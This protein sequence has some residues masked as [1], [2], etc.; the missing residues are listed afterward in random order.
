MLLLLAALPG[1]F[2]EGGA[3]TAPALR[4]AGIH[5]IYVAAAQAGSW[6]G[7]DGITVEAADPKQAVSVKPPRVNY[8]FEQASASRVPWID[9]NGW[10]FLRQPQ[11]RFYYETSGPQAALAAAEAFAWG[12]NAMI[13][14]DEAGLKPL[15]EM[16]GFLGGIEAADQPAVADFGYIDDGSAL[17]GEV[18]NLLVRHNL[19]FKLVRAPDPHLKMTV[20][21]G[22][23]EYPMEDARNPGAMAQI[24]RGNLTDA[25]RSLRIYGTVVVVGRLTAE[26]NRMRV[27]LLN[28]DGGSRNVNG[29]RV[30]IAGQYPK[31]QVAAAGSPGAEL[32]DYSVLPDTTEFTLPE[33]K[34]YAVIDVSR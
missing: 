18:M 1:L 2:W 31:H 7:V 21:L 30:R 10:R 34:T 5:H 33:L 32:L 3:D 9:S 14:T 17:S 24:V 23:K 4:E 15:G 13:K 12:V 11:G 25:R 6:K 28:Y 19:L 29:M 8:R 16:L 22:T 20:K 26:G 27:H